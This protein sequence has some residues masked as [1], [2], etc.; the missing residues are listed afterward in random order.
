MARATGARVQNM[1]KTQQCI[2]VLPRPRN[3]RTF[4]LLDH[5]RVKFPVLR[6]QLFRLPSNNGGKELILQPL[7]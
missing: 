3:K 1:G 7:H 5:F 2:L 6:R 4:G